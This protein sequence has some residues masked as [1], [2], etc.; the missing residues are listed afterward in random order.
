MDI[1]KKILVNML[2]S[3]VTFTIYSGKLLYD[4]VEYQS[5]MIK[6]IKIKLLAQDVKIMSQD[7]KIIAQ[8]VKIK[9][10]SL[11]SDFRDKVAN[12]KGKALEDKH[13]ALN[14]FADVK[15]KALE[16][17]YQALDKLADVKSKALDNYLHAREHTGV[18]DTRGHSQSWLASHIPDVGSLTGG[19]ISNTLILSI[20]GIVGSSLIQHFGPQLIVHCGEQ[21]ISWVQSK[22]G[23]IVG[24]IGGSMRDYVHTAFDPF[25]N[26]AINAKDSI[27]RSRRDTAAVYTTNNSSMLPPGGAKPEHELPAN[28][29]THTRLE[30]LPSMN[31]PFS[32]TS[33]DD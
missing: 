24:S 21:V 11:E 23:G 30:N 26:E 22:T 9:I 33:E 28:Q 8:D 5:A 7:A 13:E 10:A 6:E 1:T 25:N 19:L 16:E 12:V 3:G 2:V 27:N 15:S 32:S 4:K 14:K 31:R 20:V 18:V 17:K 29:D